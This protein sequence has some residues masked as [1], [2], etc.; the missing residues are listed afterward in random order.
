MV[1]R[2][3]SKVQLAGFMTFVGIL[4]QPKKQDLSVGMPLKLIVEDRPKGAARIHVQDNTSV[5]VIKE[6]PIIY[7]STISLYFYL[8]VL[9]GMMIGGIPYLL[10]I[11]AWEWMQPYLFILDISALF[12]IPFILL[13]IVSRALCF[14]IRINIKKNRIILI[15]LTRRDILTNENVK[16]YRALEDNENRSDGN[17]IQIVGL[18]LKDGKYI[19]LN[20]LDKNKKRRQDIISE[21]KQ[22]I[23][24]P[25][26]IKKKIAYWHN[27]VYDK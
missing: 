9:S 10:L 2:L 20:T 23:K 8:C 21:I 12:L 15:G 13:L 24:A 19:L 18:N 7:Y 22:V 1:V 27:P 16:S 4:G 14:Y 6:Y 11:R 25:I 3:T 5:E 17:T 26:D